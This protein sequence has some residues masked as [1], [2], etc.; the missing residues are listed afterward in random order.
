M[1]WLIQWSAPPYYLSPELVQWKPYA[2]K[3][4]VWALGV[5]LYEMA[6]LQRPFN[7]ANIGALVLQIGNSEPMSLNDHVDAADEAAAA[8]SAAIAAGGGSGEGDEAARPPLPL[9]RFSPCITGL[10]SSLLCKDPKARPTAQ[11]ILDNPALST[12]IAESD[13]KVEHLKGFIPAIPVEGGG[14]PSFTIDTTGPSSTGTDSS[15][16]SGSRGM[17][18]TIKNLTLFAC[19]N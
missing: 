12:V 1:A 4:D 8:A 14:G 5:V 17:L 2:A 9:P 19:L 18:G 10:A 3:S 16:G 13:A 11:A 15:V 6:V 7:G